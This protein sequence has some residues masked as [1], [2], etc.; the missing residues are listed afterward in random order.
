ML[1]KGSQKG[2]NATKNTTFRKIRKLSTKIEG[3]DVWTCLET[4]KKL[5]EAIQLL[6]TIHRK[7]CRVNLHNLHNI[8]MK[9]VEAE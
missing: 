8:F 3:R 2:N 6:N 4:H 7:L 1:I 9:L 5:T